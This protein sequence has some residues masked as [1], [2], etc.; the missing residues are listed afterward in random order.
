M[1]TTNAASIKRAISQLKS[2]CPDRAFQ[3]IYGNSEYARFG[4]WEIVKNYMD[5]VYPDFFGACSRMESVIDAEIARI[6]ST[7][8]SKKVKSFMEEYKG[9][10]SGYSMGEDVVVILKTTH[11]SRRVTVAD[12]KEYYS[13]RGRRYN[14]SITHGTV[15][16]SV[17]LTGSRAKYDINVVSK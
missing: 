12:R 7:M 13:G 4:G 14:S 2:N 3:T 1:I 6:E 11:C 10:R 9:F 16:L 5:S 8:K 17:D 15:V